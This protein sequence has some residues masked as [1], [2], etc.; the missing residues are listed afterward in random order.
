MKLSILIPTIDKRKH[1]LGEVINLLSE[2]IKNFAGDQDVEFLINADG[3]TIG[4]K[5][6]YLLNKAN[7]NYVAFFDD[8][9]RPGEF[10]IKHLIEGIK[11]GVDCCS[12]RGIITTNG[13]PP[14]LF[15]HSLKY[16]EWKTTTNEIKYER[17]PNHLN[18]IKADI[19]KRFQFPE[20]NFGEDH[21]WSKALHESGL[22]KTEHYI[23]D[24]I[25]HY[26]YLSNK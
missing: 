3:D 21:K 26:Q 17:Y 5:R 12:L 25:Y 11:K 4:K 2:Q 16:S 24:V 23:N 18:C 15:E 8:D 7:G 19:A 6:N 22:L 10:Y 9:D 13:G 1:L 20:I 14:E